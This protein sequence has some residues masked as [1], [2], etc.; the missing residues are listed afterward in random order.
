VAADGTF[1]KGIKLWHGTDGSTWTQL[2]DVMMIGVAG[3]PT[4]PDVDFTPLDP[5]TDSR[6]FKAGLSTPGEF[7]FEQL[8]NGDREDVMEDY[9]VAGTLVYWK[10]SYPDHGTE[11]NKSK[12]VF[13]GYVKESQAKD[14][15]NP[16]DKLTLA[17]KVKVS[18]AVTFTKKSS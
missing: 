15:S 8:W 9:R 6:E 5:A 12:R 18:G 16:D 13:T 17:V 7:S 11:A 3:N 14:T 10:I 2:A 1:A 4:R